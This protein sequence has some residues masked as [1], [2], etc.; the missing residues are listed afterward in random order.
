M[1]GTAGAE[2]GNGRPAGNSKGS[3]SKF[4]EGHSIKGTSRL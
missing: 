3:S 1:K 4:T 2:G